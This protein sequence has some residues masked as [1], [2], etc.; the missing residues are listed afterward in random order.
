VSDTREELESGQKSAESNGS[1]TPEQIAADLAA[2]RERLADTVDALVGRVQP[3]QLA[4]RAVANAK[5]YFVEPDGDVRT[6]R[7]AKIGAGVAGTVGGLL[8]LRKLVRGGR[9]RRSS[10]RRR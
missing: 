3:K 6:D 7:I 9:R 4:G 2:T 8:L 10:R 1:R 5:G